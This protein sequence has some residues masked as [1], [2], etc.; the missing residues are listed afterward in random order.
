MTRAIDLLTSDKKIA[1]RNVE[2]EQ[3]R[4][5]IA[6]KK[7]DL[8]T[9]KQ[10]IDRRD[11]KAVERF[12][13]KIGD[14][15]KAQTAFNAT[16][17]SAEMVTRQ[18]HGLSHSYNM[19]CA[20]L[21]FS[22]TQESAALSQLKLTENPMQQVGKPQI[23]SASTCKPG[24][25]AA[26]ER[27]NSSIVAKDYTSARSE[28]LILAQC[29][30]ARAQHRLGDMYYAALGVTRDLSES[31]TWYR[32]AAQNGHAEAQFN[33]GVIYAQGQGVTQDL[34]E[35]RTWYL[36]AAQQ[37]HAGAQSSYG[38]TLLGGLGGERD[39]AKAT[40]WF[41]KA[42][43]QGIAIAQDRLG[44]AYALGRGVPRDYAEAR[45]WYLR[46]AEQGFAG[47]QYHIGG[48]YQRGEGVAK[49]HAEAVRW[50][51]KAA[52]QGSADAQY[53]LGIFY[54]TGMGIAADQDYPEAVIWWFKAARQ[55]HAAAQYK[56]AQAHQ[57]LVMLDKG[58][59]NDR[60]KAL[61]WAML[62]ARSS[63]RDI[64]AAD[65][66]NDALSSNQRL[67]QETCQAAVKFRDHLLGQTKAGDLAQAERLSQEWKPNNATD[68]QPSTA[69]LSVPGK[70]NLQLSPTQRQLPPPPPPPKPG[71]PNALIGGPSV[72]NLGPLSKPAP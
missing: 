17:A 10:T 25:D 26:L 4:Q 30:D 16:L 37:G 24:A 39:P 32:R 21:T 11:P 6:V 69:A 23:P 59:H 38:A 66:A 35:A 61:M 41:R 72:F 15:N 34:T 28:L 33:L 48:L 71:D 58:N 53:D 45:K 63:C 5:K 7:A 31:R 47:A 56:I 20:G 46:A 43:E 50:Y 9:E 64:R 3:E 13:S 62:A 70:R 49:D 18:S 14:L 68:V 8:E 54:E 60:I 22:K 27:A 52:A 57:Q 29:N 36:K 1:A 2:L 42:A 65:V 12:N 44:N 67:R 19:D 40:E 51:T 55:G